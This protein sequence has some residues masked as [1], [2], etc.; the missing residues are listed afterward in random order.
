MQRALHNTLRTES[1]RENWNNKLVSPLFENITTVAQ[2]HQFT[3]ACAEGTTEETSHNSIGHG[4]QVP[5]ETRVTSL[6]P[7]C[8]ETCRAWLQYQLI[9]TIYIYIY[10][11]MRPPSTRRIF[12][13]KSIIVPKEVAVGA[14]EKKGKAENTGQKSANDLKG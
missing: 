3:R 6:V 5:P 12:M 2:L 10:I 11:C 13:C 7:T 9:L 4:T 8:V 1:G 14:E